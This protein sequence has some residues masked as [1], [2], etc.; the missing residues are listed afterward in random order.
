MGLQRGQDLPAKPPD[1]LQE[2][3]LRQR[4]AV[5]ADLNLIGAGGFGER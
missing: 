2:H 3:F 1:L 5:E 4:A